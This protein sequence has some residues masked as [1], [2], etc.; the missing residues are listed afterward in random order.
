MTPTN[1]HMASNK[2]TNLANWLNRVPSRNSVMH[3][4]RNVWEISHFHFL[5]FWGCSQRKNVF[6]C[7][8]FQ[9]G[10]PRPPQAWAGSETITCLWMN[11]LLLSS[12]W[13]L[14]WR[15]SFKL[16]FKDNLTHI[17]QHFWECEVRGFSRLRWFWA[18]IT[19]TE[20]SFLPPARSCACLV[21]HIHA[22][23]LSKKITHTMKTFQPSCKT[24]TTESVIGYLKAFLSEDGRAFIYAYAV[25]VQKFFPLL[26]SW[27]KFTK[28][29]VSFGQ[30]G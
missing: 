9:N 16:S 3:G 10:R 21:E 6:M 29:L 11:L 28:S 13:S 4:N 2:S 25:R 26:E 18:P 12:T 22:F 20:A 19:K 23:C 15:H 24:P 27:E 30:F 8:K 1:I 14:H 7:G 5:T 17:H